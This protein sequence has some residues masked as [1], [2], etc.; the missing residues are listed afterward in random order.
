MWTTKDGFVLRRRWGT[1]LLL[2]ASACSAASLPSTG[3]HGGASTGGGGGG[4]GGNAGGAA[5]S[6]TGGGATGTAGGTT[7]PGTGGTGN[8][9]TTPTMPGTGSLANGL[10]T[11]GPL[12]AGR[13]TMRRL[14]VNEW[15]NTVR[16]LFGTS[17][18]FTASFPSD[19]SVDNFDTVGSSLTYSDL[20]F[21][22]QNAGAV[23]AIAELLKRPVGDPIRSKIMLCEPTAATASTCY[24]T[25]LTA[26]MKSAW[27]RAVT[28]AEVQT[29]VMLATTVQ[30][31]Q[32]TAGS[33]TAVT[34]GLSA[35]FQSVLDSP[36]FLFHVELGS[37]NYSLTSTATTPLSDYEIASR[38]SYFLWGSMPDATLTTAADMG[39]LAKGGATV[40]AQVTRMLADPKATS[41]GTDFAGQ[42]L[43]VKDDSLVSPDPT[44]FPTVD[45]AL[46][47]S[48]APETTAFFNGMIANNAPLTDI[49]QANYGYVNGR[50][51]Q[52]YGLSGVPATQTTF[53]KVS[54][55]GTQRTAGVLT[56]ET[57]LT[58]QAFPTRT[59]PVLRG[60]WVLTNM[61]CSPP[62]SPPPNVPMFPMV[63]ANQT[64]RQT[65]MTHQSI[66]SCAGCHVSIDNAGFPFELFDAV[67]NYR[68][69]DNGQMIDPSGGLYPAGSSTLTALNSPT[70]I[71]SFIAQDP[72]FTACV[73]KQALTY[74]VGRTFDAADATAYITGIAAP[75]QK[76]GTWQGL[77]QAVATSDA[78]LTTR[79]GP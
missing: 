29:E 43:N 32:T 40:S 18:T 36:Y 70:A 72:R 28:T 5:G 67:G 37:P 75:L 77:L 69:T 68:T 54:L 61:L 44:M 21:S 20:L 4:G 73:V 57:F 52:F 38:L 17:T 64:V 25:I 56:Q 22:S 65:L 49:V 19:S 3:E 51:A 15:S 2:I 31:L 14:N 63:P 27:R 10:P 79:G 62:P 46:L 8:N 35:A 47:A 12:D 1:V 60:N 7:T 71:G 33:A 74:G 13:V 53:T 42:W 6:G 23:A 55:A 58:T 30:T 78:F 34:D 11:A 66:P 76:S 9:S 50:L 26:F 41:L 16:D 59:S 48:I 39:M 24:S 45:N